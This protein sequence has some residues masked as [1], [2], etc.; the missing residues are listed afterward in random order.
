MRQ[1]II[2]SIGKRKRSERDFG[3]C[4]LHTSLINGKP[5]VTFSTLPDDSQFHISDP[6]ISVV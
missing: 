3:T 2:G 4:T 5:A 1:L 6:I